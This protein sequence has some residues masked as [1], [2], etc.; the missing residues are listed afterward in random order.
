M[1]VAA[2]ALLTLPLPCLRS[3]DTAADEPACR[4]EII[5]IIYDRRQRRLGR[6]ARNAL[7]RAASTRCSAGPRPSGVTAASITAA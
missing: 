4:D 5:K 1:C 7:D 3:D 6:V 2:L